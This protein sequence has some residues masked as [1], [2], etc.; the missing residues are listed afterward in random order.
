MELATARIEEAVAFFAK[1]NGIVKDGQQIG[2]RFFR[3]FVECLI[4]ALGGS[5]PDIH[6]Y[7]NNH[8]PITLTTLVGQ[9]I[10]TR[11]KSKSSSFVAAEDLSGRQ[12]KG[13]AK[14]KELRQILFP[15]S[16]QR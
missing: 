10:I 6:Y 11:V 8:T 12:E 14:A 9:H 7:S 16:I 3:S 2:Y 5:G 15:T 1:E 13:E 4:C